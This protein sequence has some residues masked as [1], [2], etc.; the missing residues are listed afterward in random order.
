MLD[1]AVIREDEKGLFSD[2]ETPLV[3]HEAGCCATVS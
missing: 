3:T 1:A 2:L